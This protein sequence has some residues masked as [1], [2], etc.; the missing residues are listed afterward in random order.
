MTDSEPVPSGKFKIALICDWFLPNMGGTEIHLRDLADR[1]AQN[2][3]E[4]HVITPYPGSED[5]ERFRIHRLQ[6][7]LLPLVHL[8]YTASAFSQIKTILKSEAFDVVHCHANIIS[9]TSYGSLYLCKK[10]G[11]PAV[12]TWDSILGPYRWGLALLDRI[13]GWSKW[14]VKFSGVSEVVVQDVRSLVKNKQVAVLHNALD[15]VEWKVMPAKKDSNELWIVS[16]MRLYRKKRGDALIGILP[17]VLERIPPNICVK[18][19]II[20]KGPKRNSLEVQIKRLGL[21][22]IVELT[23]YKTRDEIKEQFSRTDI[24]IQPTRWES[25]GLAALEA[26]CAGLPV[27]AKSKGGVKGFIRHGQEGLLAKSDQELADH[28]VRLINDADFRESIARHNREVTPPLDWK[29]AL[30]EHEAVYREAI[31]LI[32]ALAGEKAKGK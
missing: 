28:L 12:M 16:V 26:R 11:I 27:I 29:Q 5:G 1:L 32:K 6:V 4:V 17:D 23:G 15:V 30:S 18:L 21:E 2:G 24:Y 14:L 7:P 20:G 10:L 9:P 13:F 3:H 22:N 19:K 8:V 31:G 25:F